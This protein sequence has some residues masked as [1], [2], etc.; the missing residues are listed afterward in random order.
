MTIRAITFDLWDTLVADDSDEPKRAAAGLLPKPEARRVAFVAAVQA[1]FP[2]VSE[3]EAS[4]AWETSLEWFRHE[5]KVQHRTPGIDARLRIGL[6]HLGLSGDTPM[7]ELVQDLATMEVV[8]PPDL[9]PG[10]A[11]CLEALSGRYRIGI[12][13]DA[14]MTPGLNLRQI[15][16]GWGIAHHFELFVFSDEAG[17]AKPAAR[18]FD[19][20]TRHFGCEPHELVHV[21]DREANDILG[22]VNYGARS[23]LY[24]GVIDRGA[25]STQADAVCTHHDAMPGIIDRLS[26]EDA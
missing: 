26:E 17:A 7:P 20:A 3:A 25:S 12:V 5:W 24:T 23:I 8:H 9:A 21:G 2:D 13:S 11:A 10:V 22:P 18:V 4:A 14:I 19:I 6:E 16:E 15:L 1:R